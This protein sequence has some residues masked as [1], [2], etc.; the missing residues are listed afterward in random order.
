[1]SE[2]VLR[3]FLVHPPSDFI[4]GQF[5]ALRPSAVAGSSELVASHDPAH[6]AIEVWS[7]AAEHSHVDLAVKAA[8]AAGQTP[9]SDRR[10][11]RLGDRTQTGDRR[12]CSAPAGVGRKG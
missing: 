11:K 6:P 1:M 8:R 12:R 5:L 3:G 4:G 2:S 9:G 10:Q 7:G